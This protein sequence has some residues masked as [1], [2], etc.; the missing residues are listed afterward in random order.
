MHAVPGLEGIIDGRRLHCLVGVMLAVALIG[1][2]T[3]SN[4]TQ[5]ALTPSPGSEFDPQR[6]AFPQEV[7]PADRY[8]FYLHGKIIEDQGLPAN[9]PEFGEYRYSE[10]LGALEAPGFRVISEQ[11]SSGTNSDVYAHRIAD[12][13]DTLLAAGVPPGAIT[14]VGASKGA[15]IAI[16][17]SN[18]V[19]NPEVN[20][21]LLGGCNPPTVAELLHAGIILSGNVL[22]I[23]D[24]PDVYAG[25]CKALLSAFA[26]SGVGRSSEIVLHVGTGHGILYQ[27]LP[28]WVDPTLAWARQ[29]P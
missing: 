9:S 19:R 14:V 1:G 7:R 28:E 15:A 3:P 8:L 2:C 23:Y 17:V 29:G 13:I 11:R 6:Y 27:P 22:S 26:G 5:A 12:Q 16:L 10:I 20:Y 25:S 21:V 18:L 4:A 24:A